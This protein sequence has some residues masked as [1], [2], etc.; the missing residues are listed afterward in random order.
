MYIMNKNMIML[1]A[2]NYDL[3]GCGGKIRKQFFPREGLF[4][5]GEE[6]GRGNLFL[7]GGG[8]L[9]FFFF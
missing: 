6:K 4:F 9:R 2:N 7:L 3:G 1:G 8:P 5:P